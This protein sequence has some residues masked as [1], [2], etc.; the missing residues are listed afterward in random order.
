[1]TS[2]APQ[3]LEAVPEPGRR[4]WRGLPRWFA[5]LG[6]VLI[7]AYAGQQV[8]LQTGLARLR[9]AAEHRLDMLATGRGRPVR[10][11]H[12]PAL[13]KMTPVVQELL[14]ARW[15]RSYATPSALPGRQRLG[16]RGC[17]TCSA[18]GTSLAAGG[19]RDDDWPDRRSTLCDRRHQ[20]RAR[21]LLRR[22]HH[23]RQAWLLPVGAL[24]R[25]CAVWWR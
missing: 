3:A 8:A 6:L 17:C 7:A 23:Q 5:A 14:E 22:R 4:R 10:F 21:P 15:T 18:G 19:G 12:L 1:M 20:A 16:R 2:T 9:E 24:R 11:D 25:S 13:L